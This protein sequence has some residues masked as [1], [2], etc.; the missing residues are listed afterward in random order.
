[1]KARVITPFKDK[2]TGKVRNT[3]SEFE[4]TKERFEEIKKAGKFV[5]EVKDEKKPAEKADQK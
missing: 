4:T 3:G 2:T 5:V 1:M